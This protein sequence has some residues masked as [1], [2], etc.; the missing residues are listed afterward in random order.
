MKKISIIFQWAFRPVKECASFIVFMYVLG[1]ICS[2]A[3]V[4]NASHYKGY[5]LAPVELFFDV[6]LLAIILCL[7]PKKLRLWVKRVI[8]F[9]AYFSAIVDFYCFIKLGSTITPTMLLLLIETNSREVQEFFT[10]YL[11]LD[12]IFSSMGWVIILL[13]LHIIWARFLSHRIS[14]SFSKT[15]TWYM[16]LFGLLLFIA[17]ILSGIAVFKNK[18]AFIRLMTFD[19]IGEVEHELTREDKAIL[20]QPVYRLAFS[21]YANSLA[22]KQIRKLTKNINKHMVDSCSFKS[23][24]IVLIIGESYNRHHASLYGYEKNTTPRQNERFLRGELI[25]FSDVIAPWNLTSF[26]FKLM[27]STYVVGDKG[28]WCDYPL[29]PE[30]FRQAGYHVTFLTNQFLPKAKEAVYDF[31]GGFFLNN[32]KLNHAM[33]DERN[34]LLHPFDENLLA[35]LDTILKTKKDR[36]LIILHLLGQHVDYQSRYPK[37]RKHFTPE[38]YFRP[39]LRAKDLR[40]LSSYDN[41]TL[42]NDSIVDAIITRFEDDDALVIYVPDHGEECFDGDLRFYGRMHSAEITPHLAKNE[43]D[44][45][46]WVWCSHEYMVKHLNVYSDILVSKDRPFMTDALPFM[47]LDLAGISS[48][49]YR[50]ELNL[51]SPNYNY[52]R[53]RIIKETVDYD[54]VMAKDDDEE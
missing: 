27:F 36:N 44:I 18:T 22:E 54:K 25:P 37:S 30:I 48:P 14:F 5:A 6:Y 4:P 8:Y 34:P 29:F 35:D 53:P 24:N 19:N 33:F 43:F 16:G 12:V 46:F 41:A 13:I 11:S 20:Y 7:L 26:V 3:L 1:I 47:L 45:P 52:K 21:I 40:V 2:Q 31:S 39:D 17:F 23:D 10:S 51:I 38:G 28:E 15:P 42:Y 50:D 9:I 49:Y 32:P